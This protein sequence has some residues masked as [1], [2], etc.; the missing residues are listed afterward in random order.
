M[1]VC[2][3]APY[4]FLNSAEY[5]LK[6]VYQIWSWSVNPLSRRWCETVNVHLTLVRRLRTRVRSCVLCTSKLCCLAWF[7]LQFRSLASTSECL[8]SL[9]NG[10]DMYATFSIMSF[11]SP[12]LW[13]Y[14]RIYLYS[15]ISLYIYVVINL[16]IS[17]LVD[18][19]ETIKVNK[20]VICSRMTVTNDH[21]KSSAHCTLSLH[22][23]CFLFKKEFILQNTFTGLQCNLHCA[24]SQRSNVWASL[25]FLSERLRFWCVRLL[26]SPH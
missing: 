11:K 20:I 1:W 23:V 9:I 15:F 22:T 12:M 6:H 17:I 2:E 19:Y 13:W 26:G 7:L 16:F 24:L 21:F 4:T 5:V 18:A 3:C 25:V 10:D 14:S 8:F